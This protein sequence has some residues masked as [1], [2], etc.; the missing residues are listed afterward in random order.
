MID[1]DDKHI[2]QRLF[3]PGHKI[4]RVVMGALQ[5]KERSMVR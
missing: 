4:N 2:S 3:S 1:R 5:K